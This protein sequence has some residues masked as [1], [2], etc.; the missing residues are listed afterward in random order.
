MEIAKYE[1]EDY[2]ICSEL[3]KKYPKFCK[4]RRT[5]KDVVDI[6]KLQPTEYTNA[7]KNDKDCNDWEKYEGTST[8]I[9][10]I[11][12]KLDALKKLGFELGCNDKEPKMNNVQ[13]INIPKEKN[14]E[15]VNVVKSEKIINSETS[16]KHKILTTIT[17]KKQ[18]NKINIEP[19]NV[20][21]VDKKNSSINDDIGDDDN[22]SD[23]SDMDMDMDDA[24]DMADVTDMTDMTDII[25]TTKKIQNEGPKKIQKNKGRRVRKNA[26]KNISK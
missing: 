20:G 5:A 14:N 1:Q 7:R 13:K 10:K 2:L 18:T 9:G 3:I 19:D 23:I 21:I 26:G 4:K 11:I 12:I 15:I 8:K 16:E 25:N 17:N 24:I 22:I 6:L